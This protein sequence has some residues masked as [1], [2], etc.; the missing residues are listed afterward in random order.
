MSRANL[1]LLSVLGLVALSTLSSS[2]TRASRKPPDPQAELISM[3]IYLAGKET[4]TESVLSRYFIVESPSMRGSAPAAGLEVQP[5]TDG[6]VG[7]AMYAPLR[8][9]RIV[10]LVVS[11]GND[12]TGKCASLA[13]VSKRLGL[14]PLAPDAYHV[15]EGVPVTYQWGGI[16]GEHRVTVVSREP[17]APGCATGLII[18]KDTATPP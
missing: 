10:R 1:T 8:D 2:C 11:L 13:D 4:L 9:A 14:S 18:A 16:I 3:T 7:S 12:S 6:L 15:G 17:P 5:R